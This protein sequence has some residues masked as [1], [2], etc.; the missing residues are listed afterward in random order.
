MKLYDAEFANLSKQIVNYHHLNSPFYAHDF[1][2]IHFIS[3]STEHTFLDGSKQFKFIKSDLEKISNNSNTD[4][5]I[6]H[7]HT[8]L[9]S[10]NQDKKEAEQLRDT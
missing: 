8:P 5:I 7:Q 3:M 1:K 9:Y 10:T 6:V 4:W 2:N